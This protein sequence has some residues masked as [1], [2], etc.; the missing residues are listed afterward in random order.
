[1]ELQIRSD[2]GLRSYH[3]AAVDTASLMKFDLRNYTA[4]AATQLLSIEEKTS[5]S[6]RCLPRLEEARDSLFRICASYIPCA[7]R[8]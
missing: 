3:P 6:N 5:R 4:G 7:H 2:A 8:R 1:M